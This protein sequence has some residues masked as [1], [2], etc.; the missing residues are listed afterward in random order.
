MLTVQIISSSAPLDLAVL[1]AIQQDISNQ[2]PEIGVM[3]RNGLLQ[4][5]RVVSGVFDDVHYRKAI[6]AKRI[7]T[8][9]EVY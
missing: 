9:K 4:E 3:I 7:H 8:D 2:I 5:I 1:E 6:K